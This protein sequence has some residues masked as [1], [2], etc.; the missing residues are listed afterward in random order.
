MKEISI[1][2]L[3]NDL[4]ENNSSLLCGNGFSMNFDYDFGNIFD[5]LYDGH[6]EMNRNSK[7]KIKC[8]NKNFENK[9]L[10]NFESAKSYLKNY[11]N[12]NIKQLFEDAF[13]FAKSINNNIEIKKELIENGYINELVFGS[14]ELTILEEICVVKDIRYINIEYWT[15]LVY[16]YYA[17][18]SLKSEKYNFP[19]GNRFIT[20]VS[21]G[22]INNI[23]FLGDDDKIR[24]SDR[25]RENTIF[26][27]FTTY[28]R[29]LFT[30][31]IFNGGKYLNINDLNKVETLDTL[32]IKKFLANFKSIMT[33]NYDSIIEN[34]IEEPS[35]VN[36]LH[37]TFIIDKEEYV[38]NQSLGLTF[39]KNY[40]SFSDILI[41]DYPTN[42]IHRATINSMSR[43][44]FG[45]KNVQYIHKRIEEALYTTNV[46][47]VC[48]FGLNI[49]NDQHILR[50]IMQSFYFNNIKNPKII[51]SYFNEEDKRIFLEEFNKC[52]TYSDKLSSYCKNISLEFIETKKILEGYFLKQLK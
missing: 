37:G 45:N 16:F 13:E 49:Q 40:V 41:G 38:Y 50:I 7:Y 25:A 19:E 4:K 39:D 27:G 51:F 35:K 11:R 33:T 21:Y 15:I 6:K 8:Q 23:S 24:D 44:M 28:Y 1:L 10:K 3:E 2:E 22:S 5:R 14:S 31:T 46:S 29:F 48:I 17:L 43:N 32:S 18:K 9:C 42:K 34:L 20:A 47:T 12:I 52:I 26:N 30:I 36:H